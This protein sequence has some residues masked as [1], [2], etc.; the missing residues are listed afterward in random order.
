[1]L[2][3]VHALALAGSMAVQ[4]L[5]GATA[6]PAYASDDSLIRAAIE[7]R[8]AYG[9]PSDV[10]T[11]RSLVGSGRDVGTPKWGIAL[12]AEEMASLKLENRFA[13]EEAVADAVAPLV[14]GWPGYAGMYF[15]QPGGG[16]FV[17]LLTLP[18]AAVEEE[19]RRLVPREPGVRFEYVDATFREL[20]AAFD[21]TRQAWTHVSDVDPTTIELDVKTNRIVV[22]V[23]ATDLLRAA[24]AAAAVGDALGVSVLA[25]GGGTGY[26][27][28]CTTRDNCTFPMKA[29]IRIYQDNN[30][31]SDV[32]QC[33]M[34]F[35]VRSGG[36]E[37]F[38]TAGHCGHFPPTDWW[39]PGWGLIG[40]KIA[41]LYANL[42]KDAMTVQM[43]DAQASDDIYTGSSNITGARNPILNESICASLGKTATVDCGT[44]AATN[45]EWTG[46]ACGCTIRGADANGIAIQ[47]GDSGSPMYHPGVGA[48]PPATA[49][50][51]LNRDDG[52]FAKLQ[53]VLNSLGLVIVT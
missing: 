44:V 28:V 24:A 15:D 5:G 11:V 23:A 18:D 13:F 20:A 42:G 35:H 51:I 41:T 6:S 3:R 17:V 16:Q 22:R 19:V 21:V 7:D 9:L 1:M 36:D 12:T 32:N 27:T 40:I 43:A 10:E 48:D 31:P 34:A 8:A 29:G 45:I 25:E 37:Q 38:L 2:R 30:P 49:T 50:G 46:D 47:G 52:H 14:E 4:L 39:H 26:E 53:D 33:T